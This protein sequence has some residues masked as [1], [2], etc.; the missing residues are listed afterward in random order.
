MALDWGSGASGAASGAAMGS[1]FGPWGAAA[2]GIAGGALGLFGG[3]GRK[4]KKKAKLVSTLD[5]TQ[6]GLYQQYADAL[7][8]KGQFADLYNWDAKG[9]NNNFDV[10]VSR[11]AYRNF[12]ENII[13]GIT[14]QF[15]QGNVQNSSYTGEAL[16]RAGR[17]VQ[18]SLDAQRS[19][20]QFQGQQ[21]A[22][23]N[24][25]SGMNNILNMQTQAF[26]QPGAPQQNGVDSILS[27][28]APMGGQ[29]MADYFKGDGSSGG[30]GFSNLFSGSNGGI[31]QG[32]SGIN[33][34]TSSPAPGMY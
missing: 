12:N 16:G 29:F 23:Q 30:G 31:K 7:N 6:Q 13:P 2:G 26:M 34:K 22:N 25:M 18:E 27:Q 15:R 10:N 5:S 1:T 4:K 9:A 28:L 17:N 33:L 3:G 19:N 11:P 20:M 32:Q 21:S 14:G 24:K 8:G